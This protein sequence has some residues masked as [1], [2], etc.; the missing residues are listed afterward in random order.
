MKYKKKK[1]SIRKIRKK[2]SIYSSIFNIFFF[3]FFLVSMTFE[4][5]Y[6]FILGLHFLKMKKAKSV[7]HS[8]VSDSL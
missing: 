6:G 5:F 1:K 3:F 8:V 4:L 2:K 7:S